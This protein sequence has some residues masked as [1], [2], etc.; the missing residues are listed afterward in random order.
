MTSIL[1]CGSLAFDDI[2]FFDQRLSAD[3]RNVKLTRL[4]RAFGG[5]AMNIAYN[6]KRLGDEPL[7]FAYVGDDYVPEYQAHLLR[8]EI[9][10]RGIRKVPDTL[11][12]RG[13]VLTDTD[14]AQF[15][16]FYPGPSLQDDHARELQKLRAEIN[17]EA[18]A[19]APDVPEK[20]LTAAHQ[21]EQIPVR[22]WCPGQYVELLD[23]QQVETL[24]AFANLLIVN[25]HEWQTLC[26]QCDELEL[27]SSVD[28][29]I[30]TDGPNPITLHQN[31]ESEQVHVPPIADEQQVDPTGCG[32]AF[33]AAY[34][35]YQ[36][37][38]KSPAFAARKAIEQAA[39]CMAQRGCQNH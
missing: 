3:T 5:C 20:M 25:A 37:A 17:F 7:P 35:H 4:Y 24:V 16:A 11:S 22:L 28:T 23:R 33:A 26:G 8:L 9:S 39:A 18:V 30:I 34:L 38:Q 13:I 10:Q 32:D 27:R 29:L 19:I 12:S 15:T 36:L 14:G 1:V 2:G 31:L 6:L 21:L